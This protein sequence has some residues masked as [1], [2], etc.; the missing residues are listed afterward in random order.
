[1]ASK[2]KSN[3][4]RTLTKLQELLDKGID[5][6]FNAVPKGHQITVCPDSKRDLM[7]HTHYEDNSIDD[8]IDVAHKQHIKE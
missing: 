5:V 7:N 1:M 2:K 4:K 6:C 8:I 3:A